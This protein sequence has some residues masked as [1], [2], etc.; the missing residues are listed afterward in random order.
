VIDANVFVSAV[1]IPDSNAS[2][3]LDLARSNKVQLLVSQSILDE[4]ELVLQYPKL[5]KRHRLS[6]EQI[7]AFLDAYAQIS[8]ITEGKIE[9]SAIK[10]D[11]ADDKYLACAIEGGAD[12]IIS[13]DRH[14]TDLKT[15]RG[16][17]IVNPATFL[18]LNSIDSL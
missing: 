9:V 5:R 17:R 16:I 11:P 12:F 8:H 13:G 6:P 15:F 14:L 1:L 2:A 10:D 4:I 3:I 18:E 7:R